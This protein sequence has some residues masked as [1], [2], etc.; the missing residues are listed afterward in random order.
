MFRHR[1][2]S[3]RL[4]FVKASVDG[5]KN[6]RSVRKKTIMAISTL[7]TMKRKIIKITMQT[8][9]IMGKVTTMTMV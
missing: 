1:D 2:G 5:R 6:P 3:W 9:S 7:K 8:I 4:R